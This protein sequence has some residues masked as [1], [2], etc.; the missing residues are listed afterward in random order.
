MTIGLSVADRS[1][2]IASPT[3]SGFTQFTPT[4]TT[5]GT[6]STRRAQS[7]S[8]SPCEVWTP[9]GEVKLSQARASP[10][11]R[12]Q[13]HV[14]AC[15][16]ENRNRFAGE[17]VG[18]R[19]GEHSEAP[20]VEIDEFCR[21]QPVVAAVLGAVV[22]DRAVGADGCRDTELAAV[23]RMVLQVPPARGLRQL[24]RQPQ[25]PRRLLGVDSGGCEALVARLV[26][27][28]DGDLRARGVV[29]VVQLLDRFRSGAKHARGP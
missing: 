16:L 29:V 11:C 7:K 27:R 6:P 26:A 19:R 23:L 3:I 14:G 9:S 13:G 2:R 5:F 22:Q 25:Q 12:E 1:A 18:A 10:C 17:E 28:R 24:D 8:G 4:A 21:R 20:R 15:L